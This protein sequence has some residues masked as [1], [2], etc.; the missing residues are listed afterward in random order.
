MKIFDLRLKDKEKWQYEKILITPDLHYERGDLINASF[1]K[2]IKVSKTSEDYNNK[3]MFFEQEQD[4]EGNML[5][6]V[7][8][9]ITS[10]EEIGLKDNYCLL[11]ITKVKIEEII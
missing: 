3:S 4:Q 11:K 9:V 2:V 7:D 8:E 6:Q 1:Y 10:K 5:F